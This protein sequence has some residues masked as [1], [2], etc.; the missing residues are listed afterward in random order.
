MFVHVFFF[1]SRTFGVCRW[2]GGGAEGNGLMEVV[3]FLMAVGGKNA[4]CKASV[5]VVIFATPA[6]DYLG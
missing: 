1:L 3:L 4:M 2:N 6:V 5:A